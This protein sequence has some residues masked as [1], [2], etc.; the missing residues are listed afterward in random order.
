MPADVFSSFLG[1]TLQATGNNNNAWGSI[2]NGSALQ[3]AERAIAGNVGHAVT[4]GTLDLSPNAPPNGTTLALDFVQIFSGALTAKQIVVMPNLSKFWYIINNTTGAFP[5]HVQATGGSVIQIPQGTGKF[6]VCDGATNL[7]RQDRDTVGRFVHSG[8]V[9][10]SNPGTLPSDGSSYLKTDYPDL[11]A[12]IGTTF[13]TVDSLH[14]TVPNLMDTGR[15]LRSTTSTLTLGTYQASQIL[16]HT[17]TVSG[18]P[19][20]GTLA[21]VSDGVHAHSVND[22][23]HTHGHNANS[24]SPGVTIQA[25]AGGGF[26]APQEAGATISAAGTGI[27]IATAGAHTHAMTGA[28]TAGT[29]ANASTGGTEARPEALA[30][31]IGIAY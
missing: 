10:S 22:P 4:G 24:S 3:I 6:V 18:A 1:M 9:A 27:T 19:G 16:A 7:W 31:Y 28:P 11:F 12:K 14:F 17:H 23:T 26:N 15:F 13:G 8:A 29:L 21:T 2:L 25:V 20:I 30:V 5:L